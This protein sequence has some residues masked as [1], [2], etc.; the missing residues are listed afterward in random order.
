MPEP[1]DDMVPAMGVSPPQVHCNRCGRQWND[2][3]PRTALC[4]VNGC[5]GHAV[6]MESD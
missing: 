5:H 2:P 3:S 4:R 1:D 6:L